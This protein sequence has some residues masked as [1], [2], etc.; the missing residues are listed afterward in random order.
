MLN[1]AHFMSENTLGFSFLIYIKTKT[2]DGISTKE[3]RQKTR[4]CGSSGFVM[5]VNCVGHV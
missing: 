1:F 2:V 5:R 4:Y 3:L